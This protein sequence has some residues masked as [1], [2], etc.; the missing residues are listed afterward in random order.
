M[1][2]AFLVRFCGQQAYRVGMRSRGGTP[3][4]MQRTFTGE[5]AA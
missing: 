4:Q 5:V 2:G 1:L 3:G